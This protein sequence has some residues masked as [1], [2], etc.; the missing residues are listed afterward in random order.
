MQELG[1][2]QD[3]FRSVHIGGTNGKG[4]SA[5]MLA[6]ILQQAGYKTGLY[7]SPHMRDFRERI[8]IDG[9]MIPEE[10][11]L[12]FF[13]THRSFFEAQQLSFFEMTVG[14]AFQYFKSQAVHIA[15]V[16]VGLGGRLDS[17]NVI[18]PVVAAITNIGW[19]HM[20]LLGDS[21]EAIA[22]EKAGIIKTGIPVV[23]G[24][25]RPEL[26]QLFQQ[27][28]QEREAPIRYPDRE[29]ALLPMDLKGNYQIKNQQLV[30]ALVN[31][32]I[33]QGFDIP[34]QAISQG[35]MRVSEITGLMGR[36]QQLQTSPLVVCD[37][38]HNSAGLQLVMEQLIE[39]SAD[40]L[41][42]VI[43]MVADKDSNTLLRIL[44]KDAAC[45]F[46]EARIPRSIP[47]EQL[48]LDA[49]KWGLIGA[50]YATVEEGYR[51]AL[52]EAQ[53]SDLIFVGGSTFVVS[54]LLLAL[55]QDN[56]ARNSL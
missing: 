22:M 32:L 51:A 47:A 40:R 25:E 29:G 13:H 2:P 7:T 44:P 50:H 1:N 26:I 31:Q 54:D 36:W 28:A 9:Q 6:A 5:H 10:E 23:V 56:P 49:E 24:E 27:I 53:K 20:Q 17:T 41:H 18:N 37:T 55:D 3:G 42:L 12:E 52:Q 39:L 11:V 34:D 48:R 45:Y 43:G 38:A 46:V 33:G 14:L 8:R 4:S 19:D 16:E 35:L 15:V 30:R 21:L